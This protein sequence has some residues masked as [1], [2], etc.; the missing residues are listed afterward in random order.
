MRPSI[1]V[2]WEF[3]ES[4]WVSGVKAEAD[5]L[6]KLAIATRNAVQP[7]FVGSIVNFTVQKVNKRSSE[8]Y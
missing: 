8:A 2:G 6:D 7:S 1:P 3:W 4:G 5:V